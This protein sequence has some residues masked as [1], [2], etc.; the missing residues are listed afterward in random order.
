MSDN[1]TNNQDGKFS[2]NPERG[3]EKPPTPDNKEDK[4][5]EK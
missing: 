5:K 1:N 4:S 2:F 3:K